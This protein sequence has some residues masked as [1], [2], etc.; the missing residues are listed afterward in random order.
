MIFQLT[1]SFVWL[2]LYPG[3]LR[4]ANYAQRN[5]PLRPQHPEILVHIIANSSQI[6]YNFLNM[7]ILQ[8]LFQILRVSSL[9]VAGVLAADVAKSL[10][11]WRGCLL[12]RSIDEKLCLKGFAA[13]MMMVMVVRNLKRRRRR[14]RMWNLALRRLRSPRVGVS[15][16]CRFCFS[17]VFWSCGGIVG[18]GDRRD[19]C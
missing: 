14:G 9:I 1:G 7:L 12:I 15:G 10:H 5:L 18:L 2:G 11:A 16:V 4:V 8:L 6:T 17:C 3:I 13:V 19:R